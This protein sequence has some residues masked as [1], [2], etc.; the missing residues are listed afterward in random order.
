MNRSCI[1]RLKLT[2]GGF[3]LVE[4][5]VVIGIIALLIS[6]L[7]PSLG[8]AREQAKQIQCLSNLRQLGN[9]FVMYF[10]ENKNFFPKSAPTTGARGE[11]F[12]AWRTTSDL[13][14]SSIAKYMGTP[15]NPMFFRCP[16]DPNYEQRSF[17]YSYVLNKRTSCISAS[18]SNPPAAELATKITDVRRPSEKMMLYEEDER[19]I[20]DGHGNPDSG[21]NLLAIRHDGRKRYPDNGMTNNADRK[22]NIAFCDGHAE[23]VERNF[24]HKPTP[25]NSI[26]QADAIVPR[27]P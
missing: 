21:A 19:T 20:D 25:G 27:E 15:I 3:T 11:D 2:Q 17:Q 16:T 10:N 1:R 5:L 4:L 13:N 23:Y 14:D 9:A 22:G 24:L 26:K 8:R 12:I 18:S 6:I 7:L